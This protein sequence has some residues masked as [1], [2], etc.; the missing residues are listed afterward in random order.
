ME[1]EENDFQQTIRFYEQHLATIKQLD[2][3][4]YFELLV[5]YV[6]ALFETGAYEKHLIEVDV[7]IENSILRNIQ[8]FKG[9]DIYRKMLFKKAAAHYNLKN[10]KKADYVLRELI[11]IDPFDKDPILFLKKCLRKSR[12]S[13][14]KVIW[15]V[16]IFL[17]LTAAIVFGLE[18][19]SIRSLH[20][21]YLPLT[22][23]I[24]NGVLISGIVI[25]L[26]GNFF[27][28]IRIERNVKIFVETIKEQKL[29]GK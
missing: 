28:R 9:E 15:A 18:I 25:L 14:I 17:F 24:R 20:E 3:D 21:E 26:L 5:I 7:V 10:Y 29:K 1:I 11:K 27:H 6:N 2:F 12:S 16:A 8:Y 19:L 22:Q 4:E 23:K 13:V